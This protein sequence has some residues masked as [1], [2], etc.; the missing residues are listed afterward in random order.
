MSCSSAARGLAE[1]AAAAVRGGGGGA[2]SRNVVAVGLLPAAVHVMA[3]FGGASVTAGGF[4]AVAMAPV[5]NVAAYLCNSNGG[6]AG[7]TGTGAAVGAAGAA[8][9]PVAAA[10]KASASNGIFVVK[11]LSNILAFVAP[12]K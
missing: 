9:A 7:G 11:K 4:S 8:T 5:A 12:C 10:N 6:G 1:G 3:G 2:V